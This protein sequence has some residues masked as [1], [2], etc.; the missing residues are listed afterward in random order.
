MGGLWAANGTNYWKDARA[1][2]GRKGDAVFAPRW[3]KAGGLTD[4]PARRL[5]K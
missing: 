5:K 2:S 4:E 1:R 3:E